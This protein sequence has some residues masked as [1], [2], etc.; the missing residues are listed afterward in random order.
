MPLAALP[1][2]VERIG[3]YRDINAA[4]LRM[5]PYTLARMLVDELVKARAVRID[6]GEIVPA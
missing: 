3:V 5:K 6:D 4:V 2:Y 1:G